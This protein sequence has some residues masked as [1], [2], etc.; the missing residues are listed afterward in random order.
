[1]N[2][3][4]VA[5]RGV[6]TLDTSVLERM[7]D[8]KDGIRRALL[9]IAVISLIVAFPTF[10]NR[11]LLGFSPI[12]G[13]LA[14]MNL[15]TALGP[16]ADA[17]GPFLGNFQASLNIGTEIEALPTSL[18]RPL[19]KTLQAVGEYLSYP[20]AWIGG[21]LSYLIWVTLVA[22]LLGGRAGIRQMI[23]TTSLHSVP[24]TLN[25]LGFIPCIGFL[26]QI[27]TFIWGL[28]IYV[29]ATAVA[30]DFD[31]PKAALAVLLPFFALAFVITVVVIGL[32]GILV[33]GIVRS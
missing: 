31:W 30:N 20:F 3:F 5:V 2:Q 17:L 10:I 24:M 27:A 18:P 13:N 21:W 12:N 1:M 19:A 16:F 8:A 28:A 14:Q 23:S 6:L 4:I 32:F 22:K 9:I 15:E 26:I 33:F 7:R 29:K 11:L 25:A